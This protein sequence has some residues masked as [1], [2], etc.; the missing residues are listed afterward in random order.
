MWIEGLCNDQISVI[1]YDPEP[2]KGYQ[3]PVTTNQVQ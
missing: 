1:E 3:Y 2:A